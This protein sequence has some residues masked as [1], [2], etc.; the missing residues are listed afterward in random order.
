MTLL[1]YPKRRIHISLLLVILSMKPNSAS[2]P[3]DYQESVNLVKQDASI[4]EFKSPTSP[5]SNYLEKIHK[6]I[7]T[8]IDEDDSG[9]SDGVI[10]EMKSLS[11]AVA[12]SIKERLFQQNWESVKSYGY[13]V[14]TY[15]QSGILTSSPDLK[16]TTNYKSP[17]G[18]K[19]TYLEPFLPDSPLSQSQNLEKTSSNG[20]TET[21]IDLSIQSLQHHITPN[22]PSLVVMKDNYYRTHYEHEDVDLITFKPLSTNSLWPEINVTHK[23]S[24]INNEKISLS[25]DDLN[26]EYEID[27]SIITTPSTLLTSTET[28]S[29]ENQNESCFTPVKIF[30][31]TQ[32]ENITNSLSTRTEII[33]E[34]IQS[35]IMI[36]NWEKKELENEL[37]ILKG[38][39]KMNEEITEKVNNM[40]NLKVQNHRL[41]HKNI[42][43]II[44]D[45]T[46]LEGKLAVMTRQI[47]ELTKSKL[48]LKNML[49]KS[50]TEKV[51][52]E[53][54]LE[55]NLNKSAIN[56]KENHI[57]I[58][59]KQ[60][61]KF[62]EDIIERLKSQLEQK[63]EK[64]SNLYTLLN[65]SDNKTEL[66]A[67]EIKK[68]Q[69]TVTKQQNQIEQLE[70]N[71]AKDWESIASEDSQTCNIEQNIGSC[72][73][74]GTLRYPMHRPIE[75][76]EMNAKKSHNNRFIN[77]ELKSVERKTVKSDC[78]FEMPCDDELNKILAL[79]DSSN[80]GYST[81]R[82]PTKLQLK[83]RP[84]CK[85]YMNNNKCF[86]RKCIY[87]HPV[88]YNNVKKHQ[89]VSLLNLINIQ[90]PCIEVP[91]NENPITTPRTEQ[92]L[93][94]SILLDHQTMDRNIQDV[95]NLS[96]IPQPA[97]NIIYSANV[98]SSQFNS[99]SWNSG[100]VL[101]TETSRHHIIDEIEPR[102]HN[103]YEYASSAENNQLNITR[104]THP[105]THQNLVTNQIH[106]PNTSIPPPNMQPH[107]IS[108]F[109][110]THPESSPI[111][112][113]E[114][115]SSL[116][117]EVQNSNPANI[118]EKQTT[119]TLEPALPNKQP[120]T[121]NKPICKFFLRDNCKLG[122]FCRFPHQ[123]PANTSN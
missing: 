67:S 113:S 94:Q 17:N 112:N 88:M 15:N 58:L 60:K 55:N 107:S 111:S 100:H 110:N 54:K 5:Q 71:Q 83:Y 115:Y 28:A 114:I 31:D 25:K 98:P 96:L 13:H 43:H 120:R 45:Y 63:D 122:Y 108:A 84:I 8:A 48:L 10:G 19:Q 99:N 95:P 117:N 22:K 119:F 14:D 23:T 72:A 39:I 36:L 56:K 50:N 102:V 64:I 76:S 1:I 11:K 40:K 79:V 41:E 106:L 78:I 92:K 49:I 46:I 7:I 82:K 62:L 32:P 16:L 116:G 59:M 74:N 103:M 29:K 73:G 47:N 18:N 93:N 51:T 87:Q 109:N 80:H 26:S 118:S 104:F 44:K 35:E 61:E 86:S 70:G 91:Q 66:Y 42:K 97:A 4:L 75:E 30:K 121:T 69:N 37:E 33:S 9:N 85:N 77:T 65:L 89:P 68:L 2:T 81:K 53:K 34:D 101:S 123:Q 57:M 12:S 105:S 6:S 20:S 38:K 90:K 52:V 21:K 24:K 3:M 27:Y